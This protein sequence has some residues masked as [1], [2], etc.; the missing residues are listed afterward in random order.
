MKCLK[1]CANTR[2]SKAAQDCRV[3][4][5]ISR[6]FHTQTHTRMAHANCNSPNHL[7]KT[8]ADVRCDYPSKTKTTTT[9]Y[10]LDVCVVDVV[11]AVVVVR[12]TATSPTSMRRK[13]G[14]GGEH[15]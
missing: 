9:W 2:K 12:R 6:T 13:W 15:A 3:H 8:T 4:F 14:G 5:T 1:M 7:C 11:V 10:T